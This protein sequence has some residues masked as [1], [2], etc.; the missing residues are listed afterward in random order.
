MMG[1]SSGRRDPWRP[2]PT[3]RSVGKRFARPATSSSES[4]ELGEHS[5]T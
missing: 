1:T 4:R 3:G 2:V 5:I